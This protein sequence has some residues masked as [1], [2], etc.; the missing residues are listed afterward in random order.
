MLTKLADRALLISREFRVGVVG[1]VIF[2]VLVKIYERDAV[3][4]FQ[5]FFFLSIVEMIRQKVKKMT[6]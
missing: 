1:L 5:L 2:L 3:S 6:K 4:L